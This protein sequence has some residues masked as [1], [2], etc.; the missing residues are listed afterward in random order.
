MNWEAVGAVGEVLGA[1]F[2]FATLERRAIVQGLP[3]I[4]TLVNWDRI[5]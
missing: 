2:V 4:Y 3:G 1:L 5:I